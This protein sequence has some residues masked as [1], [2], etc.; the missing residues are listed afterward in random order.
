MIA[1]IDGAGLGVL[2]RIYREVTQRLRIVSG[3]AANR[4]FAM[5]NAHAFLPIG[6]WR[7]GPR[8]ARQLMS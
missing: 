7:R 6:I 8:R 5:T 2:D 1:F 3:P 4:L